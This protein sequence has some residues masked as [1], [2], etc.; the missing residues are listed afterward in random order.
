MT[1]PTLPN[2]DVID[3]G[4]LRELRLADPDLRILEVRT[5]GEFETMHIP[6]SYNVPL[7]TLGEH[8]RDLAS[9]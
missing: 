4:R 3:V 2:V 1:T 5:G 9:V 7:D 6:G 8:V